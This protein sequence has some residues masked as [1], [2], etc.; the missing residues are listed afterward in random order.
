M[1]RYNGDIQKSLVDEEAL[2]ENCVSISAN[3]SS[4]NKYWN[5][6]EIKDLLLE[7]NRILIQMAISHYDK[8]LDAEHQDYL[9]NSINEK[10]IK[11]AD[12][13]ADGLDK[14][15]IED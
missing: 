12:I 6:D 7:Y 15:L 14:M 5:V 3:L 10:G 2:T 1:D 4:L 11:I 9:R 8:S 13:I